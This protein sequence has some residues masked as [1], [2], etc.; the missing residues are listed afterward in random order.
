[1]SYYRRGAENCRHLGTTDQPV[2][3][4]GVNYLRYL[5]SITFEN[6]AVAQITRNWGE[7]EGGPE[8]ERTWRSLWG[9]VTSAI[10]DSQRYSPVSVRAY[11]TA[12]PQ[13]QLREIE[14]LVT[15]NRAVSIE[16]SD[17]DASGVVISPTA[18]S[19]S[20]V[21]VVETVF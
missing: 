16:W 1:M 21:S 14:I 3:R 2:L 19:L 11:T 18:R 6:E 20:F 12:S 9:A 8:V 4:D 15:P 17:I 13:V 7:S 5:G 10:P